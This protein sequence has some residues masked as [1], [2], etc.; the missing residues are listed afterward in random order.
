[1]QDD[2]N[3]G[4]KSILDILDE[5]NKRLVTQ[6]RDFD[7]ITKEKDY[8]KNIISVNQLQAQKHEQEL[9]DLKNRCNQYMKDNGEFDYTIQTQKFKI[10]E[11]E[12]LNTQLNEDREKVKEQLTSKEEEYDT[13]LRSVELHKST[14]ES[15]KKEI[16]QYE[17]ELSNK[18]NDILSQIEQINSLKEQIKV[19]ILGE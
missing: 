16:A 4:S 3:N 18:D 17:N 9:D 5:L 1:M 12:K 10:T 2:K 8:L 15:L 6:E 14:I 11:L 19:V 7:I 13:L